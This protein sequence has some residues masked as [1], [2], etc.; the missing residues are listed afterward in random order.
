VVLAA[1]GSA[2]LSRTI[3]PAGPSPQAPNLILGFSA[4][5]LRHLLLILANPGNKLD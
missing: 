2:G 1:P 5:K 4:R 3:A